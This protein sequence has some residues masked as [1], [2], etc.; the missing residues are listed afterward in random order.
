MQP[1][2]FSSSAAPVEDEL[3]DV[4]VVGASDV[5]LVGPSDV[6]VVDVAGGPPLVVVTPAVLLE[7]VPTV[8]PVVALVVSGPGPQASASPTVNRPTR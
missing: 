1:Q 5:P 4:P 7:L 6:P 3:A 8:V 2:G